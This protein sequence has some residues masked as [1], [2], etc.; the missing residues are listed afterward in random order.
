MSTEFAAPEH[1]TADFVG[2]PGQRTFFVQVTE[3]GETVS[4]LVEKQQVAGLAELVARLLTDVGSEPPTI[5]DIESMRLREPVQPRWRAG[6]IGVGLDAQLGRFV[7]E[8]TE[9]VPEDEPREPEELRIWLTEEQAARLAAHAA[10]AV[11]QGRPTCQLCGQP[12]EPDGHVCPRSNG[13][14]HARER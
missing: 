12:I 13:D 9:F 5:W 10:W 3:E 6:A 11:E 8:V 2:Q 14:A 1:A 7:V 4:V